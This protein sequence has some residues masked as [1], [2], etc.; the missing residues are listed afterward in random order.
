MRILK[1]VGLSEDGGQLVL[2]DADSGEQFA[3]TV[4]E[5]LRAA[6]IHDRV[7]LGQLELG[8]SS[9]LRPREIQARVR[10]GETVEEVAVAAGIPTERALRFAAPVLDERSHV[11]T[12]A[13]RS[14]LRRAGADTPKSLVDTVSERL[15]Q[16]G[17]SASTVGWDAWRRDDGKWTVS[18]A[19]QSGERARRALFVYDPLSRVV[20]PADDESRWLAGEP[21][22]LHGPQPR[23]PASATSERL[24][25]AAPADPET[26]GSTPTVQARPPLRLAPM[27]TSDEA[28]TLAGEPELFDHPYRRAPASPPDAEE[29]ATGEPAAREPAAE[30]HEELAA[31]EV[32]DLDDGSVPTRIDQDI[33]PAPTPT[34]ESTAPRPPEPAPADTS[35]ANP[36]QADTDQ[37]DTDQADPDHGDT[38]QADTTQA[39]PDQGDDS[40]PAPVKK[41]ARKSA[42]R[43]AAVPSW[44]DIL[45]GAKNNSD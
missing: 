32:A 34:E 23:T 2:T 33:A 24:E 16:R 7:R 13:R 27:E 28:D 26:A 15:R 3:V 31:D 42:R 19:Y 30:T 43:R 25:P 45:F 1:L 8:F 37:A 29:P 39:D 40:P 22:P 9:N 5:R 12:Q 17:L 6:V 10:A 35:Q 41:P 44:D 11:A 36:S 20:T 38:D 4:D 21:G 18:A 14:V